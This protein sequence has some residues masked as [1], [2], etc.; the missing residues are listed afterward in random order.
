MLYSWKAQYLIVP[1]VRRLNLIYENVTT[2]CCPYLTV[3]TLCSVFFC[4]AIYIGPEIFET[5]FS[6]DNLAQ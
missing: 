6:R 3:V 4:S 2:I 5:G 1:A